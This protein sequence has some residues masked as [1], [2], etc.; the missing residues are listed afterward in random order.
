MSQK[1]Y[2]HSEGTAVP[3]VA[4]TA[5]AAGN[6]E[7][8]G[9]RV[10]GTDNAIPAS[11]AGNLQ[12]A[13]SVVRSFDKST[14]LAIAQGA[15]VYWDTALNSGAGY[16]TT[17][18]SATAYYL[19]VCHEAAA[20]AAANVAVVLAAPGLPGPEAVVA[21]TASATLTAQG[22]HGKTFV[23]TGASGTITHSLPAAADTFVGCKA[24][25]VRTAA[26]VVRV[27]P[28]A[29]DG[30]YF[31]PNG[32]TAGLQADGKYANLGTTCDYLTIV[33]DGT[34]WVATAQSSAVTVEA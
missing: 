2:K 22:M 11:V 18:P 3:R 33:F 16:A 13:Y 28:A 7:I 5:I 14:S 15:H 24:T 17:A 12:A 34:N 21:L 1:S 29:A 4:G 23:N 30:I 6:I 32:G 9:G 8:V 25:F 19:G 20:T 26:Q 10:C 27:D 31:T